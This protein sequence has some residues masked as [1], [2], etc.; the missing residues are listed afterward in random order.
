LSNDLATYVQEGL[1][2]QLPD[3]KFFIKPGLGITLTSEFIF[4]VLHHNLS[5]KGM[6]TATEMAH[7]VLLALEELDKE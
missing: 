5:L 4:E 3:G 7:E 1:V 2:E 6:E